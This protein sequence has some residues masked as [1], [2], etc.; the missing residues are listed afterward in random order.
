MFNKRPAVA[1]LLSPSYS[2][3][4][5]I[6]YAH[7][8]RRKIEALCDTNTTSSTSL[9]SHVVAL[10]TADAAVFPSSFQKAATM[11]PNHLLA[12]WKKVFGK[13][14]CTDGEIQNPNS[15]SAADH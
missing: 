14:F 13:Y 10:T 1:G 9:G 5:N 6:Q 15:D 3:T 2:S 7:F 12:E 8:S 4:I 11:E